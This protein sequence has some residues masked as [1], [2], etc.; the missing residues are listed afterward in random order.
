[1][2]RR[3]FLKALLL[4]SFA[5]LGVLGP[6]P[7]TLSAEEKRV[8]TLREDIDAALAKGDPEAVIEALSSKAASATRPADKK[9]LLSTLGEYFER[10]G[11]VT[12][13]ADRFHDAAFADPASRDDSLLLDSAR[14]LLEVG[15]VEGAD[16][17]VRA[18]TL[19]SFDGVAL[20]RARAYAAWI[21][22]AT[23]DRSSA[24]TAIRTLADNP[25]FAAWAPA[26]LFTLWW[27]D[28]DA[29]ARDSLL[30]KWPAS[31]E[32]AVISGK[33]GLS[34]V[35]FWYLMPR[36]D[37]L[38]S[39][40]ASS[41]SGAASASGAAM[42]GSRSGSVTGGSATAGSVTGAA[43]SGNT[44]DGNVAG[45]TARDWQQAGFFKNREYAEDLVSA[46]AK[47]GFKAEIHEEKRPSGTVYFAVLVPEDPKGS[48]AARLKDAGFE[49]YLVTE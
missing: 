23:D 10:L 38:V 31:P 48:V 43:V 40:F 7:G 19:T 36:K 24:L 8:P 21:T 2:S 14:C 11:R 39:A 41:G 49:S 4:A 28:G 16:A 27:A 15:D 5:S 20:L 18:V 1:M 33:I 44:T 37:S 45:K 42:T 25:Q 34:Q 3:S 17:I 13:A 29:E 9:L 6:I 35:P 47:A 22:L 46:L 32:A 30:K 26:F 12:D